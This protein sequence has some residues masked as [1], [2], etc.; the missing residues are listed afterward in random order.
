M[1]TL[2][3]LNLDIAHFENSVDPDQLASE[4][5]ADLNPH[6][7]PLCL[8][9]YANNWNPVSSLDKNLGGVLS[10]KNILHDKS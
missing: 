7:L 10:I 6:C 9:I 1:L 3:M 2:T 4:K 5:P 8:P